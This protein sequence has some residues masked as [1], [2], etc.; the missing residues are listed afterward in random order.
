MCPMPT[1]HLISS[2]KI[3]FIVVIM[4]MNNLGFQG[5]SKLVMKEKC[6]I[7]IEKYFPSF[8]KF[9]VL[10]FDDTIYKGVQE[11]ETNLK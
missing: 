1:P 7:N 10:T 3:F 8:H 5:C 9:M 4:P 6:M 2:S 11:E